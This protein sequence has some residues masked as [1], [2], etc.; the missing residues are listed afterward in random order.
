MNKY[1]DKTS[2]ERS[3][4]RWEN[5][6]GEVKT[7]PEVRMNP[8]VRTNDKAILICIGCLVVLPFFY[9]LVKRLGK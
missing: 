5:E 1:A 3:I 8:E 4:E 9:W 2:V 6:G 7:F